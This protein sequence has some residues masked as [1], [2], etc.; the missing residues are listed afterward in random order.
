LENR[1]RGG[2]GGSRFDDAE[3]SKA[4]MKKRRYDIDR[5]PTMSRFFVAPPSNSHYVTVMTRFRSTPIG[6]IASSLAAFRS[7]G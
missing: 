3:R 1:H 2:G 6:S 7:T 4:A 5:R